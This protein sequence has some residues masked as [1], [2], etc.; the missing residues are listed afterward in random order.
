MNCTNKMM[1]SSCSIKHL[2]LLS[3]ADIVP[4]IMQTTTDLKAI[5]YIEGNDQLGSVKVK[6]TCEASVSA[7]FQAQKGQFSLS[8]ADTAQSSM[9]IVGVDQQPEYKMT[10]S[11]I[12]NGF[13]IHSY[14]LD[15]KFV[16]TLGEY[17]SLNNVTFIQAHPSA[18][19]IV[20]FEITGVQSMK[21]FID[22]ELVGTWHSTNALKL[23]K[24]YQ[25]VA[26]ADVQQL[27][28]DLREAYVS[29]D[30]K[31][32]SELEDGVYYH[33]TSKGEILGSQ[34]N[35]GDFVQ[36]HHQQ[37]EMMHYPQ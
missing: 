29:L 17:N 24:Y 7:F 27:D 26:Q 16:V 23:P 34:V 25:I 4:A 14:F 3:Y 13:V 11:Q 30:Y 33:L 18:K 15:E 12:E 36:F 10:L 1:Q 21:V 31:M 19:P 9:V 2:D 35:A 20:T 6:D 37:S 22:Y 5:A 28:F 8:G 32:P